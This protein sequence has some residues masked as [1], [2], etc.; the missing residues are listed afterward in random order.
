MVATSP[1]VIIVGAG[2]VGASLATALARDGRR[3]ALIGN[4]FVLFHAH[5]PD[6]IYLLPPHVL[7]PNDSLLKNR[8]GKNETGRNPIASS[9]SFS[10]PEASKPLRNLDFEVCIGFKRLHFCVQAGLTGFGGN[11][12]KTTTSDCIEDID[13]I[14]VRGYAVFNGKEEV[15]LPYPKTSK[16]PSTGASFHHGRFIMKL[17]AEA[18]ACE[19]IHCIEGTVSELISDPA[20]GK[21]VGVTYSQKEEGKKPISTDIFAPLTIVVDGCFSKFRKDFVKREVQVKSHFV[22]FVLKNCNLPYPNHGHV[23]LAKPSPILLYQ[24]GTED[25]RI[26]VDIPGKLP[27]QANGELKNYMRDFVGPQLPQSVQKSFNRALETE[28]LRVM[29]NSF[30]PPSTNRRDGVIFLGDAMN[31]RHPLTGG[32]MTVGLWDAVHLRDSLSRDVVP[33]LKEH[34]MILNRMKS[35]HWKRKPLASVVNILAQAL[36]ALFSAGDADGDELR[37]DPN[38]K[39][40]Q[41]ACF[42]YFK[43]GGNC[44][45]VPV[46][47]LAGI[48]HSPMTLVYH[49]FAVAF[50]GTWLILTSEPFWMV[51]KNLVKSLVVIYTAAA[52]VL[53]LIWTELRP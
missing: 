45:A 38:L 43:L 2:V 8:T 7:H 28:R 44:V 9:E 10:N 37:I 39:A 23:V 31:M 19:N 52:V 41:T 48:I 40:L 20:T 53:P 47:L 30:L 15:Y 21:I 50:Y 26:L 18:Q 36:Y 27:S 5:A 17:R 6:I 16:F 4:T 42:G 51:P 33:S 12:K 49:F 13:A 46:G 29:P 32:G 24:I 22:G 1:E 35:M 3:V 25:T 11:Y 34:R 14:E